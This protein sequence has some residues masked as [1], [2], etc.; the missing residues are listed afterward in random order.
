VEQLAAEHPIDDIRI[1][2]VAALARVAPASIYTH[3]GTKEALMAAGVDRI[4]AIATSALDA[5]LNA[6]LD[7]IARFQAVG[8]AYLELLLDHPAITKYLSASGD[9]AP[10]SPHQQATDQRMS[11]LRQRFED[12]IRDAITAGGLQEVDPRLM[13]YFLMGAWNGVAALAL[14][15]DGL[16]LP[17]ADIRQAV[18]E[19]GSALTAGLGHPSAP[20]GIPPEALRRFFGSKATCRNR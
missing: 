9:S 3:F 13:S 11:L 18:I 19:A 8:L 2:D 6:D 15:K 7:P 10:A 16:A 20:L 17:R 1:E 5:A 14:R 12:C 4:L